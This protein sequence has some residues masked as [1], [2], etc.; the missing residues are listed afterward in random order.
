[1]KSG[2]GEV[3]AAACSVTR[4]YLLEMSLFGG[5]C[6]LGAVTET[7]FPRYSVTQSTCASQLDCRGRKNVFPLVEIW[8]VIGI[9]RSVA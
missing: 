3:E 2:I 7:A 9:I 4:L 8:D 5:F 1:M 6:L